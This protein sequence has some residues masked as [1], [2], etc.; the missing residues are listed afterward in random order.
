MFPMDSQPRQG[1]ADAAQADPLPLH[2][3]Q[4]LAQQGGGPHAGVVTITPGILVNDFIDQG[5]NDSLRRR[6]SP[7]PDGVQKPF[8]WR[9]PAPLLEAAH[10]VVNR[11]TGNVQLFGHFFHA[12][13]LIQ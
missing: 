5:L 9:E 8:R 3:A 4:I 13:A 11:L 2:F 10:P 7:R 1:R 12:L 6:R